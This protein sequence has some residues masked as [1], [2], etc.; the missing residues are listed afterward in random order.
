[1]GR[2]GVNR[3]AFLKSAGLA[4]AGSA[5]GP[6]LRA[7]DSK[8][9]VSSTPLPEKLVLGTP[10][11]HCDWMLKDNRPGVVWGPEGVRHMLSIC[12]AAGISEVYWRGWGGGPAPY[13]K[14][15]GVPRG[16]Y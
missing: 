10:I 5:A 11:T 4:V 3:R 14:R 7:A 8:P 1:M 15:P 2:L 6:V 13:K 12:K 9:S 16:S